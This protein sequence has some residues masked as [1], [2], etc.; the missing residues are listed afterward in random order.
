MVMFNNKGY[1]PGQAVLA[2][3][4]GLWLISLWPVTLSLYELTGE[5]T[6][7]A[8]LRGLVHWLNS[9]IRPQPALALQQ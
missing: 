2:L 6:P 4:L 8:Q 9:A 3:A 1:L 7:A 5:E